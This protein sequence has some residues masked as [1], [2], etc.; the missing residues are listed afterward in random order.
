MIKIEE[1]GKIQMTIRESLKQLGLGIL[2]F[3]ENMAEVHR[4]VMETLTPCC[5]CQEQY[6]YKE[7]LPRTSW[8]FSQSPLNEWIGQRIGY[9][10]HRY[11]QNCWEVLVQHSEEEY[12]LAVFSKRE[13]ER[14]ETHNERARQLGREATL[15]I[16]QWMATLNFYG[17]RCAYCHGPYEALEHR[18]PLV[19]LD[20][21]TTAINCVPSCQSCNSRKGTR[22]PDEIMQKETSLSPEAHRRIRVEMEALHGNKLAAGETK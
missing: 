21:G 16:T 3:C 11:C 14:V 19:A 1:K 9:R 7:L 4:R 2:A 13:Y 5:Q 15:T 20:G 12:R 22:H 6:L 10:S 8:T 18:K 17:W